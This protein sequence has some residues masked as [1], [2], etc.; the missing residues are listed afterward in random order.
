MLNQR[1][2]LTYYSR[3]DVQQAMAE[4]A[5]QRE[6]AVQYGE[7]GFGKRP[8][9][10]QYS[11]DILE[12][13]KQGA[14]SFHMSEERWSDPLLLK[15]SL[16]KKQLDEIR[17]GFDCIIDVDTKFVGFAKVATALIIDLLRFYGI[18]HFGVK[19]SGNR[20]FHLCVPFESFPEHVNNQKIK[21][22][23]PETPRAIAAHLKERMREQLAAELLSSTS[24]NEIMKS[25]GLQE[26]DLV[27]KGVFDPY[28]VVGIDTVLISSRHMFRMPYSVNEKSGLVSIPVEA[29]AVRAF[30]L[31][32][33][34]IDQVKVGTPFL[35]L[36]PEPEATMLLVD[37][38]DAVKKLPAT[39]QEEKKREY[40]ELDFK[41][42][43]IYFPPCIREH[44]LKGITS[45]GRKRAVF[46]MINF[47][48]SLNYP[49]EEIE[50]ILLA[51]NEKN[52][53]KLK[54]GYVLSQLSWHKKQS[55]KILPPNCDN[56]IYYKSIGICHP[57][58]L[59][60]KIKN[61]VQYAKR[62]YFLAH[63]NDWE[64]YRRKR[65]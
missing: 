26:K 27:E 35:Q 49:Y 4:I 64:K 61:P 56:E 18:R 36:P 38:L 31:S 21:N 28:A 7:S 62:K 57:D 14:T 19:F 50:K 22:L 29:D 11:N 3:K 5:Q 6:I 40:K 65:S 63:Q 32:S 43:E 8:D 53:E 10:I 1:D 30:Q 23:F 12:L 16:S 24:I 2:V 17:V 48:K 42:P 39:P 15:P 59:C 13:A 25:T 52:Y 58:T 33:A 54:E 41:M 46:I 47:F 37:A 20:G 55:Q 44:C 45:D 34:K 60:A 9:V 51:W